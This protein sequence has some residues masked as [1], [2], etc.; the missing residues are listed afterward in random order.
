MNT[1]PARLP[2]V[3]A[4]FADAL[5]RFAEAKGAVRAALLAAADVTPAQLADPDTRLPMATFHALVTAAKRLTQTPALALEFGAA[6]DLRH[7]SIAG[8]IAHSAP[9][10]ADALV[11]LNR[12]GRLVADVEG[13]GEGPRFEIRL[14][15]GQRWMIDRRANPNA[16]P[17]LTESTWSRFI[18]W[19]RHAFPD[20]TYALAAQVSHEAPAYAQEYE[21]IWQVPVR[22]AAGRN[23]IRTTLDF[24]EA[25]VA[26]EGRYAFGVLIAHGDALLEDLHRQTTVRGRVEAL[27][28]ARLH[29]GDIGVEAVAAQMQTSRQT[30]YRALKAEGVTFAEVLDRLRCKMAQ[31][32]LEGAKASVHETAYLVGFA[33]ASAFSRAFKRWTGRRPSAALSRRQ[34]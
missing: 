15:S 19:T 27:L 6:T 17:E 7:F 22:F 33:D 18:C 20:L 23:A 1:S 28:L 13:V 24:A 5:A 10:M 29:T 16:F 32:Y 31:H 30:I 3:S 8:L 25:P 11:Q 26:P 14:E 21:R 4:G 9:T 34:D 2:T 12:Y